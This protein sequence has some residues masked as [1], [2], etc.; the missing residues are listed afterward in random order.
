VSGVIGAGELAPAINLRD[1]DSQEE[2]VEPWTEGPTIIAFFKVTCPVC[3]MAAP[4]IAA[5]AES[6]ARVV[7]VGEDPTPALA[8]FRDQFAQRVPTV[9]EPAPYEVSEA[10]GVRSV[11]SLVL[12]GPDGVVVDS[13]GAWDREKWNALSQAAGGGAVSD[14]SDGLPP[15]R[16][17]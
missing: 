15:F 3:K 13:A 17:G 7:A 2:V 16:P 4:K 5:L 12:V 11:P 14:E 10:Y 8:T 6:G 1:I 9:S